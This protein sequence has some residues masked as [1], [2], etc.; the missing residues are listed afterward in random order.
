[1]TLTYVFQTVFA[2][3][4]LSTLYYCSKTAENCIFLAHRGVCERVIH[5][6][7]LVIAPMYMPYSRLVGQL[8]A[9]CVMRVLG[10]GTLHDGHAMQGDGAEERLL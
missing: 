6:R 3:S 4:Q 7:V 8:G 5:E 9:R 2:N 10:N 1:M